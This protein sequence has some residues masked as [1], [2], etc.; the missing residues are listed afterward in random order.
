MRYA[1]DELELLM[2]EYLA[3]R[4]DGETLRSFEQALRDDAELAQTLESQRKLD[5]ALRA[6]F[7]APSAPSEAEVRDAAQRIAR[8]TVDPPAPPTLRL[9]GRPEDQSPSPPR[10]ATRWRW[11]AVAA[12]VLLSAA[13]IYRSIVGVEEPRLIPPD[14]LYAVLQNMGWTPAQVCNTPNEFAALVKDRLGQAL[15]PDPAAATSGIALLGWGYED[16][17]NGSPLSK[18]TMMLLTTVGDDRVLVLIDRKKHRRDLQPRPGS[19]L[20]IFEEVKGNLVLY[21]ITPSGAPRVLP[22]LSIIPD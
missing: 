20:R 13:G 19:P 12:A 9:A 21:E 3:G 10:P 4:L 18:S 11:I 22:H 1:P 16:D 5:A 7:V 8:P 17:Y 2:E 15:L 6:A 14:Q